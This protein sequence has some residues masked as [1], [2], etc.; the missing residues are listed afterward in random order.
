MHNNIRSERVRIGLSIDEVA[1]KINV[2]PS[3]VQK[4]ETQETEPNGR[5]IVNLARLFKCTPDYLL[6]MDD[7]RNRVLTRTKE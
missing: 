5:N 1:S 4:W 6:D 3:S 2:S 7:E